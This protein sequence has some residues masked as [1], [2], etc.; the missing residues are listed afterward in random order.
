MSKSES[1]TH[2]QHTDWCFIIWRRH[3]ARFTL[4]GSV[5]STDHDY[6]LL[7]NTWGL[8]VIRGEATNYCTWIQISALH[9]TK[10]RI[11]RFVSDLKLMHFILDSIRM[12]A[13]RTVF[14]ASNLKQT[15]RTW[16]QRLLHCTVQGWLN[17]VHQLFV[18]FTVNSLC[19]DVG[20]D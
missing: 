3:L 4:S 8:T 9:D 1:A 20:Q 15:I 7:I 17:A 18:L 14:I 16:M 19:W 6:D 10:F 12:T 11:Q 5:H 2:P 13:L